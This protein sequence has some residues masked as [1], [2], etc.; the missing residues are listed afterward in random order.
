M[1]GSRLMISTMK[2][3][4]PFIL[5]WLAY[6]HAIGFTDFL[7]Y[8]NDCSDGTDLLLD[9]LEQHGVVTHVR[10]EVLRRGAHKS[11]LKYALEH[12]LYRAAEWVFVAD[13]DEF[14]NVK[15]GQGALDDL[16]AAFPDADAIPITWRLFSCSGKTRFT[17]E[18]L[19]EKL[20]ECEPET[21]LPDAKAR[22]VK[23]IF[24][25][26]SAIE[27][28]GLHA[29][30]FREADRS[31]VTWGGPVTL[32][33]NEDNPERP[34][35]EFGYEIAQVNHYAVRTLDSFLFKK[36]RGRANHMNQDLGIDYWRRWNRSGAEDRTIQRHLATVR[37][38]LDI[39]RQDPITDHL[40]AGSV[41]FHRAK[42]EELKA[43]TDYANLRQEIVELEKFDQAEN[44]KPRRHANRMRL[45]EQMPTGG[46]CAEI[47]VW[48]GGFSENIIR[49]TQPSELVLIDP[50]DLVAETQDDTKTHAK[51]SDASAMRSMYEHV[52][53][54]FADNSNVT[55]RRGFSADVLES[56]PDD[57]FDWV[58]I[59]GN[60]LYDFVRADL[61]LS[62]SKVKSGGVIAGDDFFW[63]RDGRMHVRE[64]VLDVMAE[65]GIKGRPTRFGQQFII[66]VPG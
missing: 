6:H 25:P 61:K 29:P 39:L 37:E 23:T 46:R 35:S 52:S 40:H 9:R 18:P 10:N 64:A 2:D 7:I 66:T 51:H 5:E 55:I 36:F 31:S 65:M 30:V 44:P 53:E 12:A 22:F 28:L 41:E 50:W 59:D 57:Y 34:K 17:D 42:I 1:S 13:A 60:H 21:A 38:G 3:E 26:S 63:K 24:R 20:T 32:S 4:G 48:N 8:T 19:L 27:R 54:T 43:N 33:H 47:G 49:I 56:Y 58:Y 15:A 62:F 14:L 11:A 45:L 16:F